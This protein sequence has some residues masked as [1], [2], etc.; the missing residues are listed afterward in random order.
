ML[1]VIASPA[2]AIDTNTNNGGE[3]Q[4]GNYLKNRS[5]NIKL[6]SACSIEKKIY[7]T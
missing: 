1:F 7:E 2:D 4:F 6:P 3:I 5:F